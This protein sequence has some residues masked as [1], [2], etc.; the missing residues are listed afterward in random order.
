MKKS[1]MF[2]LQKTIIVLSSIV[3]VVFAMKM[4]S[5][6][7]RQ[8]VSVAPSQLQA[9]LVPGQYMGKG[10]YSATSVYP[11]GLSC[12]L[13]ARIID[14]NDTLKLEIHTSAYDKKTNDLMYQGVRYET[15]SY[16][17]NHG[18]NVFR[19]SRSFI[20]D[21]MVSSSHGR[22]VNA[23]PNSLSVLSTGSWH[24][25]DREHEITSVITSTGD[26]M[27]IK[28]FNDG[29]IPFMPHL[30]MTETYTRV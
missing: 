23:T 17:P 13:R 9:V 4:Y 11:N 27:T 30:T 8:G 2:D 29:P 26:G 28:Y 21:Q 1:I 10:E 6:F 5:H 20:A 12:K 3:V 15:Y 19:N 7:S 25:S 14:E 18:D 16:K 24:I 22:V